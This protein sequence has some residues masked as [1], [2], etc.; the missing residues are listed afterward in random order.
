[1]CHGLLSS[2][3]IL[4]LFALCSMEAS[5]GSVRQLTLA[6]VLQYSELVFSG[7]VI[8]SQAQWDDSQSNITTFITFEIESVIKGDSPQEKITLEFLGG[9]VDGEQ[10]GISAMIYPEIGERGVYFASDPRQRLVHPLVGWSQGH[11]KEVTHQGETKIVT[12]DDQAV[13]SVSFAP[14]FA[15]ATR[16]LQFSHGIAEGVWTSA[17]LS[18]AVSKTKFME[19]LTRYL[20]SDGHD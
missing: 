11:F 4:V 16:P 18:S 1:M 5:A 15:K 14:R 19:Q 12:A 10:Q 3:K 7:E 17:E 2:L 20:P 9:A 13:V 8:E 6:E